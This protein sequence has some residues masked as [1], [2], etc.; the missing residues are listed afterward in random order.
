[1]RRLC[2]VVGLLIAVVSPLLAQTKASG[3]EEVVLQLTRDWLAADEHQDRAT[4]QRIIAD[5]FQGTAP[6]GI[7]VFK[8][9]VIPMEGSESGGLSLNTSE[10]KARVFTDTAIVTGRGVQKSDEKRALR[11]T[12]VFA[13]RNDRWQMVAGHLS[14]VPPQ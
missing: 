1:M 14:A 7:T 12:V 8:E 5:D 13:K 10:L 4:L 11:F 9:D 2:L 3:T 6:A